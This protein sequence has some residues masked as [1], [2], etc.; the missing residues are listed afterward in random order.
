MI[1]LWALGAAAGWAF[2]HSRTARAKE[3]ANYDESRVPPYTLPDPLVMQDGSRVV[4]IESWQRRRAEIMGLFATHVYGQT[5][6]R[7]VDVAYDVF[8]EDHNALA[9]RAIRRQVRIAFGEEKSVGMDLL[10]YLPKVSHPAPTFLGLNFKGNH[11]VHTDP[12][13]RLPSG[14]MRDGEG[15]VDHRATEAE[16]GTESSRWPVERILAAGYGLATAYYGDLDP[17]FDDGFQNGIHRLFYRP[18]QRRPEPDQWGAIGAWAW[19]LSRALDYLTL[20]EG[21][22]STRVAVIGHSRLGKTA[23]WAAAQDERFALAISNNS[24]CGGAALSRR[25]FGESVAIINNS[26]PHWFCDNFKAYNENETALPVDQHMLIAAIA[27]RPVYVAS[28]SEDLWAD[29]RGEFLA[30]VHA[31]SVYRLL[32]K[33]GFGVDEMP[34]PGR[35]VGVDIGYHIRSGRHALTAYDWER[36]LA[37]A[38]RHLRRDAI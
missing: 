10:L 11:A 30:C 21:V 3:R 37:F 1:S 25:R 14:W 29:P 4:D 24:G 23:L 17:D 5:P 34:E 15:V 31:D 28:A 9:G 26:F 33:E 27:P 7:V 6:Q 13:I 20:D 16:R 36:Y 19:G 22:D 32:G 12:A 38:D 8:D 35:S 18:G 2:L